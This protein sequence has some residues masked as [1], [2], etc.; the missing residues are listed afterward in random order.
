MKTY[1]KNN[2]NGAGLVQLNVRTAPKIKEALE[3]V[4]KEAGF[5][6]ER[7]VSDAIV[8]YYG[9][10]D[11]VIEQRRSLVL[12]AFKKLFGEKCPFEQGVVALAE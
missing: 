11:K 4:A 10:A 8:W 7:I 5:Q 9:K 1:V 2:R 6:Q 12:E 3:H